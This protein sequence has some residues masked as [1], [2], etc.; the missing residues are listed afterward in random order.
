[1]EDRVTNRQIVF[2]LLLTL[3]SYSVVDIS[4][5]MATTAGYGSWLTLMVT[6]ILFALASIII[7]SLKLRVK[8]E[9]LMEYGQDLIGRIPMLA[10]GLYYIVYFFTILVFLLIQLGTL[11]K[12]DF[13][14]KT[15]MT[16]SIGIGVVVFCYIAYK[17]FVT[18]ARMMEF[19][20][21]I[22]LIT[23][24]TV[25]ILMLTQGRAENIMPFF[26]SDDVGS[27]FAAIKEAIFPFLGIELLLFVPIS[28]KNGKSLI[29]TVFLTILGIGLFYTLVVESSIMKLGM[30]NIAHYNSSLI[31]AIR[32]MELPF[33]D[34]LKRMDVLFLT[35]GY[36]GMFMGISML[37]TAII[38]YIS[39]VIPKLKRGTLSILVGIIT[40]VSALILSGADWFID[41]VVILGVYVGLGAVVVFP[42]I[43]LIVSKVKKN[44]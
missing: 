19:I 32:D 43:L 5:A 33:L 35:V 31:V 11:L 12:T 36:A 23:A 41:G 21:I 26:N 39:H 28:K 37:Y 1:M 13:L 15:P 10:I 8:N 18:I 24:V 17:G 9:T 20:G 34:F 4:R 25:H 40:Y 7:V 38:E 14:L 3:T 22:Y 42:A 29:P 27:Y 44:A 6:A 2:I 16:A 30:N